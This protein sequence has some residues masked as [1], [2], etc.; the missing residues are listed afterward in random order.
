MKV[1]IT[2]SSG[3]VGTHIM[4]YLIK[5]GYEVSIINRKDFEDGNFENAFNSD[6]VVHCAWIR[7]RDL[8]SL[9][10]LKFAYKS[11]EFFNKVKDYGVRLINLGSSSE[12]GVKFRPMKEDMI[13]EPIN[14]YGMAKLIVTLYAKRLGFNTLRLFTI[15]GEGGKSFYDL[16]ELT[17]K[18][19]DRNFKRDFVSVEIVERAVERLIHA[20]HLYGEIINIG[21]GEQKEYIEV[22]GNRI[23][24]WNTYQQRQYE[25]SCWLANTDKM[26]KLLNL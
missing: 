23:S 1:C 16:F 13:C 6:V 21:S 19:S 12:Y 15:T 14:V 24:D 10:H 5:L 9:K 25:P 18:W 26:Y 20:N 22:V 17:T 8:D 4:E 3:F 7:D 2:G 11:C